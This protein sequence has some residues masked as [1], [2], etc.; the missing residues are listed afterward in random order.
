MEKRKIILVG[1]GGHCKSCIDVI[2]KENRFLIAG[3]LDK[4][5]LIGETILG[6][7]VIGSD[8]LIEK[9][10]KEDYCFLITV[11]QIKSTVIREKIYSII[12]KADGQLP[13]IISPHAIVSKYADIQEGTIIMHNSLV[14]ASAKIGKCCILNSAS[15]IEHECEI[16]DF[17]HIATDTTIN[18]AVSI[19]DYCFIGSKTV[20]N[21]NLKISSSVIVPSG[22]RISD[23]IDK[24][25]VFKIS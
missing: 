20:V 8:E 19:G 4:P 17:C 3:I 13:V 25:G 14:N 12:K 1:G 21:N 24:A 2:E 18:G 16:G 6:Y 9:L 15:L 7:P 10:A 11:G 22:S 5:H 23:D